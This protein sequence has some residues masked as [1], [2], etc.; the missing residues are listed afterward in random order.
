MVSCERPTLANGWA[1]IKRMPVA[2]ATC[3]PCRRRDA[4]GSIKL[5][6][7]RHHKWLSL[8]RCT[9]SPVSKGYPERKKTPGSYQHAGLG[10]GNC[11]STGSC[12]NGEDAL[13]LTLLR[14]RTGRLA[15]PTGPVHAHVDV[16][17]LRIRTSTGGWGGVRDFSYVRNRHV[18]LPY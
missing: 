5:A 12:T 8:W 10:R 2:A 16:T 9:R 6:R 1:E 3:R 11:P 13:E 14:G 17:T 7:W 18:S 4:R 15:C